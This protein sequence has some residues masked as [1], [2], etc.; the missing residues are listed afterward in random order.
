MRR[1][2]YIDRNTRLHCTITYLNLATKSGRS[3]TQ[4]LCLLPAPRL[5]IIPFDDTINTWSRV[6]WQIPS[7]YT[8]IN[9]PV[10]M[11][12]YL[13]SLVQSS[14]QIVCD[15]WNTRMS[16]LSSFLFLIFFLWF[17]H[18]VQGSHLWKHFDHWLNG[19]QFVV[20]VYRMCGPRIYST[21][22]ASACG[23]LAA[24][25]EFTDI[26]A[27]LWLHYSLSSYWTPVPQLSMSIH[28]VLQPNNC[29]LSCT[30]T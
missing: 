20:Y 5:Y 1:R 13:H 24:G 30:N 23:G 25:F 8:T 9:S 7:V 2:T 28:V 6:L 21:F 18:K 15:R 17:I 26:N 27:R 29:N 19:S 14:Q 16:F 11:W 4:H 22:R 12:H 3:T 10:F